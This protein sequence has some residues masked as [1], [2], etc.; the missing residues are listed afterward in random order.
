MQIAV[1]VPSPELIMSRA[2]RFFATWP[3]GS[4]LVDG[5]PP[6]SVR[7]GAVL[8]CDELV[9]AD[10]QGEV[11]DEGWHLVMGSPAATSPRRRWPAV[12]ADPQSPAPGWPAPS[13]AV[14][15]IQLHE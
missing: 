5:A 6:L 3:A 9:L 11:A 2:A 4:V 1:G 14:G 8:A 10:P 12:P 7:D 13:N 15:V